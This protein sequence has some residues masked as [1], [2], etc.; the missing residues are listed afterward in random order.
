M[1][2]GWEDADERRERL[3]DLRIDVRDALKAEVAALWDRIEKVKARIKALERELAGMRKRAE[4]RNLA[5]EL[6][7]DESKRPREELESRKDGE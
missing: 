7:I 5:N 4:I 1:S 2:S 3:T 6:L